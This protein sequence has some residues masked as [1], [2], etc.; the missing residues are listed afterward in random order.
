[1]ALAQTQLIPAEELAPGAI[2][3]IRN[4]IIN[5]LVALASS[6]LHMPPGDLVVRDIRWVEDLQAYSSGTTAATVNNWIFTTAASATTGFVT[7]TGDKVMGDQRYVAIYGVRDLRNVYDTKQAAAAANA[8]LSQV[9]S[10]LKLNV[11]GAD[12]AIWDLTKLQSYPNQL[13]GISPSAVLI[14][15]NAA[16]NIFIYKME[17]T[18]SVVANLVL[19]GVVVEPRGKVISP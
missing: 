4:Q 2:S 16:F 17:A 13:V 19:E 12:K 15:Q 1:M 18:N 7:I 8:R 9:V 3:A 6:E 10:L 11:G 5:V 14:P